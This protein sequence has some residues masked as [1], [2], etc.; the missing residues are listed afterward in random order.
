[1]LQDHSPSVR[2][3]A[4]GAFAAAGSSTTATPLAAALDAESDVD[5]QLGIIAALGRLGTPD[6]VQ[7]LV[8]AVSPAGGRGRPVSYRV[9]A[10]E[11]LAAA[12]GSSVNPIL[13]SLLTDTEPTVRD[14]AK[15]LIAT[16]ALG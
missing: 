9:A 7:K 14:T 15:R 10:L 4:A 1:M 16:T 11:A 2:L 8:K 5:V 13:R 3:H 6:A 12:R